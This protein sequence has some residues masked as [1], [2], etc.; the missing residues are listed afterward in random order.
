MFGVGS[1]DRGHFPR[2]EAKIRSH[3]PEGYIPLKIFR[4]NTFSLPVTETP[5][6]TSFTA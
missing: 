6:A 5:L 1:G 4:A 3:I 2:A